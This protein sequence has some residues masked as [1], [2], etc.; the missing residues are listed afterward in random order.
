MKFLRLTLLLCWIGPF[1]LYAQIA[2]DDQ[3]YQEITRLD[4]LIFQESFNKCNT[5]VL[6]AIIDSDFEFYHDQSGT[7][8][9]KDNFIEGIKKNI[10]ELPYRPLRKLLEETHQVF[11]LQNNGKLYGLL[12][13][14]THEFYAV[15]KD[16]EPYLTSTA[17]FTHLWI[18]KE[19][20]WVLKRVLSYN[21]RSPR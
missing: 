13:M 12:Q 19:D 16:K 14:G 9:G 8:F 18:K 5:D 17:E 7:T 20:A 21:H 4:S 10:C 11:P 3:R 15:E 1:T 6:Y 2:K